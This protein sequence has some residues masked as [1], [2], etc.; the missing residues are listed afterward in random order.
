MKMGTNQLLVAGELHAT[1]NRTLSCQA[2]NSVSF[3]SRSG[4]RVPGLMHFDQLRLNLAKFGLEKEKNSSATLSTC[5]LYTSCR[6]VAKVKT[7]AD[8]NSLPLNECQPVRADAAEVIPR[9]LPA[10]GY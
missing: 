9:Q 5:R 2:T 3:I 1:I 6:N 4:F 8:H 7:L 10:P